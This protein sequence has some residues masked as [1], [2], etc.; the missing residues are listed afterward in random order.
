MTRM[1]SIVGRL[2]VAAIFILLALQ[3]TPATACPR[4]LG[5]SSRNSLMAYFAT[6]AALS[7]LPLGIIGVVGLVIYRQ[8]KKC[9]STDSDL[10]KRV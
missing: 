9:S 8:N 5:A 10:K 1:R 2:A 4:C 3:S 6:G 7:L